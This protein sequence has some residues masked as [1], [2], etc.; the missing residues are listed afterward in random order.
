MPGVFVK[1]TKRLSQ[2]SLAS[3]LLGFG[4]CVPGYGQNQPVR[5]ATLL[6]TTCTIDDP[7]FSAQLKESLGEWCTE[8]ASYDG[9]VQ[10]L[11]NV[12]AQFQS[13]VAKRHI[14]G[15]QAVQ[16]YT[17]YAAS[18]QNQLK[19][20]KA[21]REN[22]RSIIEIYGLIPTMPESVAQAELE[23]LA[24]LQAKQLSLIA[25]YES[26]TI[27]LSL[28]SAKSEPQPTTKS[29]NGTPSPSSETP[30]PPSA[31]NQNGT[32]ANGVPA[33][34]TNTTTVPANNGGIIINATSLSNGE[35]S[36]NDGTTPRT[37]PPANPKQATTQKNQTPAN[38]SNNSGGNSGGATGGAGGKQK[39][40]SATPPATSND[41]KKDQPSSSNIDKAPSPGMLTGRILV[42]TS[43]QP[44]YDAVVIAY[45]NKGDSQYS[46]RTNQDGQY[47]FT[48]LP[49]GSCSIR[50][51][52]PLARDAM[53]EAVRQFE[54]NLQNEREPAKEELEVFRQRAHKMT[55][56]WPFARI[57]AENLAEYTAYDKLD[58]NQKAFASNTIKSVN[59]NS[60][61]ATVANDLRLLDRDF[62][63]GEFAR[64]TV[65]FQQ[66]GVSSSDSQQK[67]FF[68][69]WLS[70]PLLFIPHPFYPD[71]NFGARFRMWGDVRITSAPQ[72]IQSTLGDF[73]V[74]F[75]A[76]LGKLKVNEVAQA[77]EFMT[78][79]EYRFADW[80]Y[81]PLQSFDRNTRER[82]GLYLTGGYGEISTLNPSESVQIFN[83]PVP[84]SEPN[85]DT[86]IAALGLT[87]GLLG[88]KYVAFIPQDRFKFY[89]EYYGGIRMKTF[90]YD[91]DTDEALRRF[92]ATF[93]ALV[94]QDE[95]M[96]GGRLRRAVIRVEAF[97]PLPFDSL[98]YLYLF[99]STKLIL[100]GQRSAGAI[101]LQTAT[102]NPPIPDP[103]IFLIQ[104]PQLNRDQY[105][106]GVGIDFLA[107]VSQ[108]KSADANK[109]LKA[110]ST[111][112]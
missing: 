107:L 61:E 102:A 44:I 32:T 15:T 69:L 2:I 20:L 111:S 105:T 28:P 12:V 76:Q 70:V 30:P 101:I 10:S 19:A 57:E 64:T 83:N 27:T 74:G 6:P 59:I 65:G 103:S 55:P 90:Y 79:G 38:K 87:Q 48:S 58:I 72:Q 75:A 7:R 112:N 13:D 97:Y 23:P 33:E 88:K 47:V 77:W 34:V 16:F 91:H 109:P 92:P 51:V 53:D 81:S 40:N 21:I 29:E 41:T 108:I 86:E 14:Q 26:S 52:K 46:T 71:P 99:G 37:S 100:G 5:P 93:E 78:G 73:A 94:G 68:D 45:C 62:S 24:D 17:N 104:S 9:Q 110:L 67:F 11:N 96:T 56:P 82:L 60:G 4:F 106:I 80:G 1:F 50:A 35:P 31:K 89:K 22:I 25:D 63:L 3:F 85:F 54:E 8:F 95:S 49:S 43:G 42:D 84:G 36:A 39:K 98:N 18:L 66:S